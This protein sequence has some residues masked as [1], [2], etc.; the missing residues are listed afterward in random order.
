[1]ALDDY[2]KRKLS[3]L[4][5]FERTVR[6]VLDTVDTAIC[7]VWA[8]VIIASVLFLYFKPIAQDGTVQGIFML[9]VLA[10]LLITS[11]IW[12]AIGKSKGARP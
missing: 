5:D 7:W 2:D 4:E 10:F 1:M 12:R 3:K 8:L 11:I 6:G 9:V